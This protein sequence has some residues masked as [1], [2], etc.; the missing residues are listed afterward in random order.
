MTASEVTLLPQPD[1]PTMPSVLPRSTEND[2]AVDRERAPPVAAG[3]DDAQVLDFEQ[4]RGHDSLGERLVDPGVD[5]VAVGLADRVAAFRQ[6]LAEVHPALAADLLETRELLERLRMV[7]DPQVEIGVFLGRVD[8]RA[9]PTACRACRRPR[10]RR[11][12][13]PRSAGAGRAGRR[14]PRRRAPSRRSPAARPACC[15][16]RKTCRGSGGRTSRRIPRRYGPRSAPLRVHHVHL[17]VRDGRH[18]PRSSG[19]PP[20]RPARRARS[21]ARPRRP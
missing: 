2:D 21:S 5:H 6:E 12:S 3:K 9:R 4:G 20:R 19:A 1:S 18:R 10:P 11:L 15:R 14:R 16:R 7:V 8:E 17:P 13:S